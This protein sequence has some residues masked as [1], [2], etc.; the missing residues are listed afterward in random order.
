MRY[1]IEKDL[2]GERQVP[3]EAYYGIET[4]RGKENF[5]ITKRGICRQLIKALAIVKKAAAKANMDADNID[6]KIGEAIM[7]ACDEILNGR[8]HGQFVTDLI[9]GGAGTS[10]HM[11]TNEVIA[12]RANEILGGRKGTY[13]FVHPNDHV[14]FGQSTNDVIPTA[15]KIA[16]IKQLK[17]LQVELKKLYNTYIEKAKEFNS[18]IKIG[19]THLQ[20]ALPITF[21]QEFNA[22]ASNLAR[23]IKRID[24]A[25]EALLEVNMGATAIGTTLNTNE[26]YRKKVI[27]Y[28]NKY[29]GE[30]VKP[31]KDL[32]DSTRN[33]DAF[34]VTSSTLKLLATNL[35][36]VANDLILMASD[37]FNEITLPKVQAGATSMPGKHNPVVA[38]MLNQICFYV[39]GLDVTITKAVEAGQLESNVYIP[40]ILMS[41]FEQ[42]S[43]LRRG[44]R[45]FNNLAI[46]DLQVN[47]QKYNT[48]NSIFL[49]TVL[50]PHIGHAK[51]C[52][53]VNDAAHQNKTIKEILIEEK[54]LPEE[55]I[56]TILNVKNLTD[57]NIFEENLNK[58]K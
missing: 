39:I 45:T 44:V 21:G 23:D 17:K 7:L 26:K 5:E 9:Q 33:L 24:T 11:N 12:N 15:G 29:S 42:L 57:Y 30:P 58:K 47:N 19:R 56:S 55:Q 46:A 18:I 34:L 35:C 28:I 49:I 22:Y 38:E 50:A 52:S 48:E 32:I 13:N 54:I 16:I 51:A 27:F 20:E 43:S 3:A 31:A 41:L 8:L 2:L 6:E 25:I 40:I 4:L 36:K 1:R 14:N 53:I 37:P 10:M